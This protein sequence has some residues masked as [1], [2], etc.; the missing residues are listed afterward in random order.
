MKILHCCLSCFYID[1]FNYQENVLPRINK[2]DGHEVLILAS[3]ESMQ[4]TGKLIYLES[5]E[6]VNNDGIKV[7]RVPFQSFLP[8]AVMKKVRAYK[9]VLKHINDFK[10]DVILFHGASAYEIINV[11]RYKKKHPEIKLYVDSHGYF[12]NTARSFLSKQILHKCIYRSC[13]HKALPLIDKI[14]CISI[15]SMD[16]VHD[17]YKISNDKLEI[18]PLGGIIYEGDKYLETRTKLRNKMQLREDDVLFVHSGK[19]DPYKRTADLLNAFTKVASKKF[20]LILI[21]DIPENMQNVLMPLIKSDL[22]IQF[23]G[24]VSSDKL[25]DYLCAADMY[26][27]PGSQSVTMQNAICCGCPVML[28]PHKSHE[29]YLKENGFFVQTIDDMTDA[30]KTIAADPGILKDMQK[31]TYKVAHELLDYKKLASRL[32]K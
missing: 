6:Y 17:L 8:L 7:I 32:Y 9:G 18:Y 14:L 15:E 26:V 5:G 13:L 20:R 10:P 30:F 31:A 29:I 23:L 21:G 25:M 4:N 3:T 28:Y 12:V 16:F 19:M 22:R 1:N 27:Q 2:E 24:W 11:A